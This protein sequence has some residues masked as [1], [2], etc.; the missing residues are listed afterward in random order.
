MKKS[1]LLVAMAFAATSGFAQLTSKSGETILPEADD[2]SI[3]V[4]ATPFLGYIGNM[5]NGNTG[6]GAP[7]W[8]FLNANQTIIGKMF[9]SETT[10]YRAILRIGLNSNKAVANIADA[11]VTSAPVYPN[12]ITMKEDEAKWG[13][14]FIGLGGG[15]EWRR[16]KGRLQGFYGGDLMIWS[17]ASKATYTYGNALA[18]SGTVVTVNSG[19]TTDFVASVGQA[20]LVTDTYG[21]SARVLTWKSGRTTGF[22]LRGFIG[23][24]YFVLPKLSIGGEFGW[25]FGIAMTGASETEIESVGGSPAS[26]GKQTMTGGKSSNMMLDVDRNAFGTGNGSLRMNFHF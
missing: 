14:S 10:A 21:N 13:N 1:S 22:G 3:G 8:N 26:V 4:D 5:F 7:T 18:A 16:G 23:A 11:T 24:E 20:N 2:W 6:N 9:T 19:T 17:S 15:M 25:G 12:L